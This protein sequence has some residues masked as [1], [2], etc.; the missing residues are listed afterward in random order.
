MTANVESL[1]PVAKSWREIYQTYNLLKQCQD[2][3]LEEHGL[4]SEQFGVLAVITYIGG[5][6][7]VTDIARWLARSTN[8]VSMIVDRMVKAGLVKRTRDRS[9]R[10]V[11]YVTVTNKA[12]AAF[13]PAYVAVVEFV[14]KI[15]QPLSYEDANTLLGLLGSVKYEILKYSNPEVDIKE[16]KRLEQKQLDNTMRWLNESGLLSAPA[17]KRRSVKKVKAA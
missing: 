5:P 8:S 17:A 11:V 6:A 16:V 2:Q 1:V 14:R 10:R 13:K 9:D 15:F 3:I 4:T 7:N 12:Q